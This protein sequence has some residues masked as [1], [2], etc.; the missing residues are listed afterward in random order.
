[1]IKKGITPYNDSFFIEK[2]NSKVAYTM[3]REH[4]HDYYEIYY[5]LSGERYYY[6][7]NRSYYIKKGDIVLINSGVIHKT[8]YAG[9]INY[10]RL[11]IH[12]EAELLKDIIPHEEY[13]EL[14]SCFNSDISIIN[15]SIQD[16][17]YIEGILTKLLNENDRCNFHYQTY[18]KLLLSE[19]LIYIN[20]NLEKGQVSYLEFPS[21][22]HKKVSEIA[23]YI[24]DNCDSDLGLDILAEK[25]VISPYYLS[26]VFKDVTGYNLIQFINSERIKK[27]QYLLSQTSLPIYEICEAVGFNSTI[28]FTRVFNSFTSM[29]PSKY[30][31]LNSEKKTH[32][33]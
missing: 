14:L 28:H 5:Q 8:T 26:R 2:K 1:M 21:A 15:S 4:S 3:H 20:R 11:L 19:L 12:F 16:Q 32:N 33:Q 23:Q 13:T 22:L 24:T 9:A 18:S 30:R 6:I 25:F 27:S 17:T 7:N 29:S 31:K 10:E